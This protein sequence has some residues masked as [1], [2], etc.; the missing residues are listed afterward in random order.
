MNNI[1]KNEIIMENDH[2]GYFKIKISNDQ[3]EMRILSTQHGN[4]FLL[5]ELIICELSKTSTKYSDVVLLKTQYNKYENLS[6]DHYYNVFYN[7]CILFI[8]KIQQDMLNY[9]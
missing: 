9:V 1:C 7:K 5:M 4:N 3:F 2:V 6:L 8:E